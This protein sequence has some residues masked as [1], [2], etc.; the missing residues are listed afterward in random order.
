MTVAADGHP[1]FWVWLVLLWTLNTLHAL[2]LTMANSFAMQPLAALAGTGSGLIGTM[3]M[4]GAAI[5]SSFVA[6]TIDG[7]ATPMPLA[8]F[9]FGVLA[10]LSLR[11]ARGGPRTVE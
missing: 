7:S 2:V 4:M 11:W 9:G 3:S 10:G 5:M 6:A 1:N 8:Y